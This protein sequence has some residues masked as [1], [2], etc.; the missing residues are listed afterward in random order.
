MQGSYSRE[1]GFEPTIFGKDDSMHPPILE[2]PV[3]KLWAHLSYAM[4]I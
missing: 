3:T 4:K 2:W 1:D